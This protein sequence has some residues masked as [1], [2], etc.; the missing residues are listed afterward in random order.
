[1]IYHEIITELSSL[2]KT[3]QT[4]IAQYERI[5]FG[6][7]YTNDEKL[8]NCYFTK[9]FYKLNQSHTLRPYLKLIATNPSKLIEWFILYSY[10]T[11][12]L[13]L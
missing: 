12:V 8:L 6:Q 3:P 4:I 5:E 11:N 13:I 2:N 7:S 1:M 10:I 9:I